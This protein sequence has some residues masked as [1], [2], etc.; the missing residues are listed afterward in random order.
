MARI[1]DYVLDVLM[2]DLVG[3]DHSVAAFLVYLQLSRHAAVAAEGAVRL[4]HAAL[5]E[6]TGLSKRAVQNAVDHLVRRQLIEKTLAQ[7]T[8][9]PTYTVRTPWRR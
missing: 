3:H 7:P 2:R 5:A 4:S 9:M 8:A 6:A 1:D